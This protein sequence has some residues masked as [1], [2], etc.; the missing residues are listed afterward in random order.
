MRC[1]PVR[2][3]IDG[4]GVRVY[5]SASDQK[6]S[7]SIL[8][9]AELTKLAFNLSQRKPHAPCLGEHIAYDVMLLLLSLGKT[10]NSDLYTADETQ[11]RNRKKRLVLINRKGVTFHRDN[12][13]SHTYLATQQILKELGWEV[14]THLPDSPDLAHPDSHLFQSLQDVLDIV[15]NSTTRTCEL[16]EVMKSW[17]RGVSGVRRSSARWARPR[18]LSP[19][20]RP[21]RDCFRLASHASIMPLRSESLQLI[22]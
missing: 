4:R 20:V 8:I 19:I 16:R 21:P 13:R 9:T 17:K 22:Y 15:L 6:V 2:L 1:R 11:V 14:L 7:G 3:R 10:I 5:D 12:T 18:P